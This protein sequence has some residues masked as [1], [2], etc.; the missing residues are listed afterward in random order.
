MTK[1]K[2][3][4]QRGNRNAYKHGFYAS[5]F[6]SD[7]IKKL[8]RAPDLESEIKAAR[9]IADR[10]FNRISGQGLGPEDAGAID[11]DTIHS[12]NTLANVWVTISTL[13][14]SHQLVA[15]KLLPVE[16]AI[17]DALHDINFAD[18]F[19]NV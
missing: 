4:A 14:R 11:E 3:G 8:K 13:A 12:I 2:P 15:G 9:I 16:T 17:L 19:N 5:N 7:E 1:N 10:I 18:G 6:S